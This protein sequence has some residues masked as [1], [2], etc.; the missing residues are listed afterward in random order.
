[1]KRRW[2]FLV[3]LAV[4]LV[5]LAGVEVY[6]A[7][8]SAIVRDAWVIAKQVNIPYDPADFQLT[9]LTASADN[10]RFWLATFDGIHNG[11]KKVFAINV[12]A[13]PCPI[14]DRLRTVAPWLRD[15]ID[16]LRAW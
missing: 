9:K 16:W 1:M 8:D 11:A 2:K 6:R 7:S 5:L 15:Q 10:G 12:P 13:R 4:L 3:G 14:L